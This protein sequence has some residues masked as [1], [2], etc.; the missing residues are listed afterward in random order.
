MYKGRCKKKKGGGK[1][2]FVLKYVTI[3]TPFL[4]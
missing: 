3:L 4:K 1:E 2:H